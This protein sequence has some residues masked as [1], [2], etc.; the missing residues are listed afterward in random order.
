VGD[1]WGVVA[2]IEHD[3]HVLGVLGPLARRD[4]PFDHLADLAGGDRRQVRAGSEPDR[5]QERGPGGAATLQHNDDRVWPAGHHLVLC[6]AAAVD[7]SRT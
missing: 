4:K 3:Q 1:A 2:G 7:T 6:L 5:V